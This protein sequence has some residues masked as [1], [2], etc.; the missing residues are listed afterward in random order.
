MLSAPVQRKRLEQRVK[1]LEGKVAAD[2]EVKAVLEGRLQDVEKNT[3]THVQDLQAELRASRDALKR[4]ESDL[5]GTCRD[6]AASEAK[7]G[8]LEGDLAALRKEMEMALRKV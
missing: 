2:A 1:A 3:S 5:E 4:A 6:L 8:A 7:R